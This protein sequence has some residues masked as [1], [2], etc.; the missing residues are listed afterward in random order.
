MTS[1]A[2]QAWLLTNSAESRTTT[3][4]RVCNE[5]APTSKK[6]RDT[7]KKSPWLKGFK[8]K[9]MREATRKRRRHSFAKGCSATPIVLLLFFPAH[10]RH[11]LPVLVPPSAS[12]LPSILRHSEEPT[13]PC[14][15]ILFLGINN[16]TFPLIEENRIHLFVHRS[17]LIYRWHL[18][19]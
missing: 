10:R 2:H 3:S 4:R 7:L 14:S 15:E 9:R 8:T 16:E 17:D 1:S 5:T 13:G 11:Q 18:A 12:S 19:V 6:S